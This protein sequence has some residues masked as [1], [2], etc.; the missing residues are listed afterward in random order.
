LKETEGNA[1]K[2]R[3]LIVCAVFVIIH[4][5]PADA[6]APLNSTKQRP[7]V[8]AGSNICPERGTWSE[9]PATRWEDA[10]VSGNGRMG[11]M[12]FGDPIEETIV[13]NHCRLFLPLGSREIVPDL[14]ALLPELRKVIG[15]QQDY[16]QAMT[17]ILGK[18]KEQ[19]FPGIIYTDPFHPGMFVRIRQPAEGDVRDYSRSEDFA[20]GEITVQ[21]TDDRGRWSRRSFVSRADNVIVTCLKGSTKINCTLRF[22]PLNPT[23]GQGGGGWIAGVTADQI[24]SRQTIEAGLVTYHNVYTKG[25]GGFDSAIRACLTGGQATAGRDGIAIQDA[26]QVVLLMRIV[27]WKTPLPKD[28]SEAWAYSPQNPDFAKENL[29]RY[30]ACPKL[31]DS[32]VVAFADT[33]SAGALMPKLKAS[34]ER[35]S[36][37]Y[38]VLLETHVA[39]HRPLFERVRLDLGASPDQRKRSSEQLLDE[40]GRSGKMSSA[41]AEKIHDAGRYMFLCCAGELPPNL[42]GLWTGTWKPAWSGDFT[43]DTNVQ[44]AMKHGFSGNYPELMEGYYRLMESFYPEWRLNAKRTYGA[45]GFLTNARASNTALLLHWGT[46]P[47]IFWA[48]CLNRDI[49]RRV[50]VAEVAGGPAQ[51][52]GKESNGAMNGTD[53]LPQSTMRSS[54]IEMFSHRRSSRYLMR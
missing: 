37:D 10:M 26:D 4:R 24:K 28:R 33:G 49:S 14:G 1:M 31:A 41:L 36:V 12:V 6:R 47:G 40:A 29:G 35:V 52:D 2:F 42:Q 32:S 8:T 54:R 38:D 27:P 18:A 39:L 16:R 7:T 23:A 20:T 3:M 44:L 15:P 9:R 13:A 19:G 43:L 48:R 34:L 22:P 5:S 30:V 25:K 53:E 50:E 46:W 21:W 17:F 45:D 11:V 51:A